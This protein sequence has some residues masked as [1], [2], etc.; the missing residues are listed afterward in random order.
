MGY[1]VPGMMYGCLIWQNPQGPPGL[2]ET[3]AD[4]RP[5]HQ[6]ARIEP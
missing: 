2:D 3:F 6:G 4:W 1:Q 5:V